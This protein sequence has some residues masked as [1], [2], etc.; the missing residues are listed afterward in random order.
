MDNV[1]DRNILKAKSI[2]N[3]EWGRD[4]FV[5]FPHRDAPGQGVVQV[6]TNQDAYK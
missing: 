5:R 6:T 1:A 2:I 3:S 4:L